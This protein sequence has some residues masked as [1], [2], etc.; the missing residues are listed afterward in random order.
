MVTTVMSWN[1]A[2]G[3]D[4]LNAFHPLHR[5]FAFLANVGAVGLPRGT[6]A[7]A[8]DHLVCSIGLP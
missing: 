6:Q 8:H 7:F 4:A 5:A 2:D 1:V 3:D